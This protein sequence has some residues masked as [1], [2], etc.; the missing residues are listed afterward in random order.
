[1]KHLVFCLLIV[2]AAGARVFSD[3]RT[4]SRACFD[5]MS[6]AGYTV[7]VTMNS[8]CIVVE[9]GTDSFSLDALGASLLSVA[10][11]SAR[12]LP[13]VP[14]FDPYYCWCNVVF[15]D[16][17]YRI[18]MSSV[19]EAY[20]SAPDSCTPSEFA[21]SLLGQSSVFDSRSED[22][23][24]SNS[25]LGITSSNPIKAMCEDS[26]F[27][28]PSHFEI[29][30]CDFLLGESVS[31]LSIQPLVSASPG[32]E[33]I[34]IELAIQYPVSAENTDILNLSEYEIEIE[35]CDQYIS[36]CRDASIRDNFYGLEL[37][38]GEAACANVLFEVPSSWIEW[39]CFYLTSPLLVVGRDLSTNSEGTFILIQQSVVP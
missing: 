27:N 35:Y 28:H 30:E 26:L 11:A 7:S 12:Y 37:Y 8:T 23:L 1:M 25:V 5:L 33:F 19:M 24:L 32:N 39:G 21:A 13:D 17:G 29:E 20:A 9:I 38:P 2:G 34:V 22:D 16:I 31:D 36:Y 15:N 14:M 3:Y 18:R 6:Q 10:S 4:Q